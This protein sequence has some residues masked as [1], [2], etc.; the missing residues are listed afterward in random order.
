MAATPPTPYACWVLPNKLL[1]GDAFTS[2]AQACVTVR[3][4]DIGAVFCFSDDEVGH[5]E[6]RGLVGADNLRYEPSRKDEDVLSAAKKAVEYIKAGKAVYAYDGEA[7]ALL[8][9]VVAGQL[10]KGSAEECVALVNRS[11]RSR[12]ARGGVSALSKRAS[13]QVGRLLLALH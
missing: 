9:A 13:D 7:A 3:G 12:I 8:A 4:A 1:I 11:L 10:G 2:D 6:V 5:A